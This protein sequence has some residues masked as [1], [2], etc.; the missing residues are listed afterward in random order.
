MCLHM[1]GREEDCP[2]SELVLFDLSRGR[3]VL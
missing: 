3:V 1:L 2:T